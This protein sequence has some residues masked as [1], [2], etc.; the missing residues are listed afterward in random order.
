MKEKLKSG[1]HAGSSF[2][3]VA[4]CTIGGMIKVTYNTSTTILQHSKKPKLDEEPLPPL[5]LMTPRFPKGIYNSPRPAP[6]YAVHGHKDSR[7]TYSTVQYIQSALFPPTFLFLK[8]KTASTSPS[9]GIR[10]YSGLALYRAGGPWRPS[11][12]PPLPHSIPLRPSDHSYTSRTP[13]RPPV[14]KLASFPRSLIPTPRV[15]VRPHA[16]IAPTE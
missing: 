10:V 16:G 7:C 6:T 5:P 13:T 1:F 3:L 14:C 8:K 11:T 4:Q 9:T 2:H 12:P 15:S